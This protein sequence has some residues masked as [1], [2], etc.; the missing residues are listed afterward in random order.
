MLKLNVPLDPEGTGAAGFSQCHFH[1]SRFHL[2][3]HE[4]TGS[5]TQMDASH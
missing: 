3:D 5:L 4:A 1:S 2:F